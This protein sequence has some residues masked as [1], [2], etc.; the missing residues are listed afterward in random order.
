MD[1][2]LVMQE[3]SQEGCSQWPWNLVELQSL[4]QDVELHV[5]ESFVHIHL[6]DRE[7]FFP[8]VSF[9]QE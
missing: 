7:G 1:R 2:D 4:F 5:I 3:L 8:I 6:D 9:L